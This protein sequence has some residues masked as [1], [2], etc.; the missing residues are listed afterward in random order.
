MKA[1]LASLIFLDEGWFMPEDPF[2]PAGPG[3]EE[4]AGPAPLPG[5]GNGSQDRTPGAGNSSG[6]LPPGPPEQG[7]DE[8]PPDGPEQGLFVCL[9]TES[10]ELSRFGGDDQTPPMASFG[11][12]GLAATTAQS[13]SADG[14]EPISLEP[15]QPA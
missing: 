8:S 2:P 13:I 15:Q 10:M 5:G 3:G 7:W 1:Y 9:P 12:S 6:G 14:I 11:V 4:A